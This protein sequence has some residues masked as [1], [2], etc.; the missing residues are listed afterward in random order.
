MQPRELVVGTRPSPLALWQ[1]RWVMAQLEA[2]ADRHGLPLRFVLRE[3][4]TEGDL[5]R[6]TPLARFGQRG[7]FVRAVEQALRRGE[8]DV[9]VH[10]LKD[11]PGQQP[12]DL[13]LAAYP[14]RDDPRDAAVVADA[15]GASNGPLAFLPRGARVG[16]GSPR[17]IAH[18][19]HWRPDLTFVPIRG[20]VD[21]RL[22]KLQGGQLDAVVLAA[23]GLRRLGLWDPRAHAL[24]PHLCLPAPG[25]GAL[26]V[27]VRADDPVARQAVELIDDLEVRLAVIAERELLARLGGGCHVPIGALA[28]WHGEAGQRHLRL[29]A[30]VAD[31]DGARLLT[32]AAARAL[33]ALL[34]GGPASGTGG[35]SL[36]ADP[37]TRREAVAA[38][39]AQ[40]RSLAHETA[41]ALLAQGAARL[42]DEAAG[43]SG[44]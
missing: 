7:I 9:A 1:A 38:A 5:D 11:L 19:R 32:A 44:A 20:N 40:A 42:L 15:R 8:V 37:G 17:R 23:A 29:Q 35:P 22:G 2:A 31:P 43:D 26:A 12:P 34:P 6:Q 16:T 30:S 25:Q 33:A 10:S 13:V 18:L 41:E 28:Q 24:E 39:E 3:I 27:Q 21:T 14:V 4:R 36:P